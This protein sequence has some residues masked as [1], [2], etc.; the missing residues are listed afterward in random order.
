MNYNWIQWILGL[1][2]VMNLFLV[3]L[4][5]GKPFKKFET[6]F[7]SVMEDRIQR[8]ESICAN[9]TF[10]KNFPTLQMFSYILCL[11]SYKVNKSF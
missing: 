3:Y 9:Y 1:F 2:L 10:S 6:D 5:P 7:D 4:K 8:L 11:H